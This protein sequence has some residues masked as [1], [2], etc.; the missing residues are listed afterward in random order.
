VWPCLANL[1]SF[2]QQYW[3]SKQKPNAEKSHG[4]QDTYPRHNV[5]AI[6]PKVVTRDWLVAGD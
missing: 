4:T 1:S 6:E 5:T 3:L 2:S